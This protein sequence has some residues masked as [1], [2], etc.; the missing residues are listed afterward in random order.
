MANYLIKEENLTS[1][2]NAIRSK[3][4]KTDKL[5]PNE[6]AAEI[7]S[8]EGG[9]DTSDATASADEIFSGETAYVNG[10]KV[11]GNFTINSELS[12]QTDLISQIQSALEGKAAG[13]SDGGSGSS[14]I[15]TGTVKVVNS[16]LIGTTISNI[17]YSYLDDSGNII[18]SFV[19]ANNKTVTL[20]NVILNSVIVITAYGSTMDID[21]AVGHGQGTVY[22]NIDG[23]S[24]IHIYIP[25]AINSAYGY[26]SVSIQ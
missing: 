18:S 3:T 23:N 5:Y 24:T 7:I 15:E 25:K 20:E 21:V 8:I 2:A 26:A 12:T 4:N 13:G 11:T 6:M 16:T 9:I 19:N 17:Y 22:S 1:I 10:S 14:G